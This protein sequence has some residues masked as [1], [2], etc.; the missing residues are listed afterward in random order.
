MTAK[1]KDV[2]IVHFNTQV[3][4]VHNHVYRNEHSTYSLSY[5]LFNT[6]SAESNTLFKQFGVG[7]QFENKM[8]GSCVGQEEVGENPQDISSSPHSP[9]TF[10]TDTLTW[11]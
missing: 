3:E 10:S 8:K 6:F 5:I 2:Y 7:A 9:Q 4:S 11:N 1:G